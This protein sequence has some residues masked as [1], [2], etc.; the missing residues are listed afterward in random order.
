M[1]PPRRPHN[2]SR[3]YLSLRMLFYFTDMIY[4]LD[5]SFHIFFWAPKIAA[6]KACGHDILLTIEEI[7]FQLYR[8]VLWVFLMIW[9]TFGKNPLKRRWRTEDILKKIV[10]RLVGAILYEP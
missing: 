10:K 4:V 2:V 3:I 8:V 7:A 5:N 9:L 6:E 1:F